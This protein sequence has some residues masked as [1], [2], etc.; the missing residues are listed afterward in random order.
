MV[1]CEKGDLPIHV[2]PKENRY[3]ELREKHLQGIEA[4]DS[5]T[6]L[7]PIVAPTSKEPIGS[8][9]TSL[10][11]TPRLLLFE[12]QRPKAVKKKGK[13]DAKE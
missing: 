3:H 9:H 6:M 11:H 1:G 7:L 4:K 8:A 10:T 13:R 2:M 12:D 5:L